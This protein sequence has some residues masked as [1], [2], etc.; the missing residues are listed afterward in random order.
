MVDGIEKIAE[1]LWGPPLIAMLVALGL[2][3][4]F[5]THFFQIR[6][7][8]YI[9]KN[10]FGEAFSG[11]F[12]ASEGFKAMCM[13]LGGTIGVGNIAG[14][15]AA[16]KFGGPGSVFWIW[17]SG[18]IGMIIKYYEVALSIKFR[19]RGADGEYF[20]GPMYYMHDSGIKILKI[21]AYIFAACCVISSLF[22][23]NIAQSNT[24]SNAMN[25][26]FGFSKEIVCFVLCVLLFPLLLGKAQRLKDF[27]N[28]FV[29]VMSIIYLSICLVVILLN[30]KNLSNSFA[31][32]FKNAFNF[33]SAAAGAG[34]YS[35]SIAISV[36]FSKG[37]FTNEAGLGSAPMA[38]ATNPNATEE[39]QGMWGIAEVFI[40][41][42]VVCSFTAFAVLGS[43]V[44]LGGTSL[45]GIDLTSA[46]FTSAVG[47]A[48]GEGML[49]ISVALFAFASIVAW[50]FYG[51]TALNFLIKSKFASAIYFAIFI[52]FVFLGAF[53]EDKF[54]FALSDIFNAP[55]IFINLFALSLLY[56]LI[57]K[58]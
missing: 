23:G 34:A 47:K 8:P 55:L 1:L 44:Y 19:R 37:L 41:T 14:V 18:F 25:Y 15:A 31:L 12:G 56:P 32:I 36:G 30:F 42:I 43:D 6:K 10:T 35:F 53:Y 26:S 5:R 39:K 27:S 45:S 33:R 48:M 28:I 57:S 13:A 4:S 21:F 38:H 11:K 29:P 22:M 52:I 54:I 9:L 16:I 50:Y 2:F 49:S 17:V 20:G 58:R 51:K 3:L 40:D 46:V 7:L 24:V